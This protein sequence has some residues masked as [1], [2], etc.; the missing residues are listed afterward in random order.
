M[1]IICRGLAEKGKIFRGELVAFTLA[2]ILRKKSGWIEK[3]SAYPTLYHIKNRYGAKIWIPEKNF[4]KFGNAN[5]FQTWLKIG[6]C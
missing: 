2:T 3:H 1:Q 5:F 6:I 4:E